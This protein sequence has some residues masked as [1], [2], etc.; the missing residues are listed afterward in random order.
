MGLQCGVYAADDYSMG[1]AAANSLLAI[2]VES[3]LML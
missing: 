2:H 3:S 1:D